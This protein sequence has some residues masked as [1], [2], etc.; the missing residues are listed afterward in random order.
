[1]QNERQKSGVAR[2]RSVPNEPAEAPV[3]EPAAVARK[4][5]DV[6]RPVRVVEAPPVTPPAA[7]VEG[8]R[9]GEAPVRPD[10][11]EAKTEAPA[12]QPK[13][14]RARRLMLIGGLLVLAIAATGFGYRWWT[15]GRFTVSTD[16]AYVRAYN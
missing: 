14:S 8:R 16:D 12:P 11:P 3:A 9:S 5:S 10:A 15:V 1:M 7:D 13:R 2:L 6:P 4:E